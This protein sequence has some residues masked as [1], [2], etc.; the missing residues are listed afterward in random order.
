MPSSDEFHQHYQSGIEAK[1]LAAGLGII[2]LQRTQAIVKRY[3]PQAPGVIYDIGGGPGAYAAWL[4]GLGHSVHLVDPVPL[5]IGQAKE[6]MAN[7]ATGDW[8]ATVG[9]ALSLSFPDDAADVVLLLGPLYHLTERA[10]RIAA[11][12]AARR[13]LRPGGFIFAAA[14]SRFA[15]LLDGMARD[16]LDDP[17]FRPIVER[18][19]SEGQHRNTTDHPSYFTTAFFH[20]PDELRSELECAGLDV[21]SIRGIEGPTWILPDVAKRWE[22]EKRRELWMQLLEK[23]ETES[24][25]LGVSAHLLAVGRK[26]Q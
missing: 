5:H 11:L 4:L 14:I 19:L 3:L 2:E 18:D 22:D 15:S 12:S 20:H 10:D 23:V 26:A 21:E 17:D 16:L 1:R 7:A 9:D 13:V 8:S 6:A 25:L 24:S